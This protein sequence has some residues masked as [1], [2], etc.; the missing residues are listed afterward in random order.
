MK[1]RLPR[2]GVLRRERRALL[3]TRAEALQN[4]GALLVEMYRRGKFRRDVLSE[5]CASVLGIDTRLAEI[6]D[7]LQRRGG[8]P[9]CDCGSALFRGTHFCPNCGR[10]RD[11]PGAPAVAERKSFHRAKSLSPSR[12]RPERLPRLGVKNGLK[13]SDTVRSLTV[14]SPAAPYLPLSDDAT[15]GDKAMVRY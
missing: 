9:R 11:L 14:E 8:V 5:S 13:N 2:R 10:R 1:P 6:D 7:L 15:K 12:S 4:V 3:E